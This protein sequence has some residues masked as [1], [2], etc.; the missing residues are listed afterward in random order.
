VYKRQQLD[1]KFGLSELV[2][3]SRQV[4][5]MAGVTDGILVEGIKVLSETEMD[6][7]LFVLDTDIEGGRLF[8]IRVKR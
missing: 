5:V 7:Q 8:T 6:V 3:G 4:F 1:K 2:G